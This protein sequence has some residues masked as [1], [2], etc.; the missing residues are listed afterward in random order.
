MDQ[1]ARIPRR[2][3]IVDA[4]PAGSNGSV[5]HLLADFEEALRVYERYSAWA[6]PGAEGIYGRDEDGKR[7]GL[8][9]EHFRWAGGDEGEAGAEAADGKE[10]AGDAGV[11]MARPVEAGAEAP[12]A[13]EDK[14]LK[15]CDSLLLG[16]HVAGEEAP[17]GLLERL[18]GAAARGAV[19]EGARVYAVAVT[20]DHDPA[21]LRP[22]LDELAELCDA[23][24]LVW[25]GGLSVGGGLVVPE[26]AP[27]ARM[28]GKRR[29]RS[30]GIDVVIA[31]VRSGTYVGDFS[32]DGYDVV[33]ARCSL[34]RFAY[35]R[36]TGWDG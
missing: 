7:L 3:A 12:S 31:A 23:L 1:S 27:T 8:P 15:A 24:G 32:S 22:A 29:A 6:V 17:D 5:A 14:L 9:I 28:G 36:R 11:T 10:A 13:T 25:S 18:E 19:S 26:Q 20:D 34:P 33:E 4:S 30:E 16:F 2:L 21:A 35:R